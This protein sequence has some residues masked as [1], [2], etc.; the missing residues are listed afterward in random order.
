MK[1]P[2]P[3]MLLFIGLADAYAAATEYI[4]FPKDAE[5]LKEALE[6]KKFLAHP[7]LDHHAGFYTDDT[8][9]SAANAHVLIENSA[10]LTPLMFADAY[11]REFLRGGKRKGYSASFQALLESGLTSGQELLAKIEPSSKRNGA[12][13]RAV[14]LGVLKTVEEVLAVAEI[15]AK[16]THNTHEG[17]F[18]ARTVAL[19]S[20]FA[21]YEDKPLSGLA[22]Y[23]FERLPLPDLQRFRKVFLHP[24]PGGPV[25]SNER[26]TVAITTVHAVMSLL[27]QSSC[28]M[29]LLK[30]ALQLGGDTDSVAAIAWGIAS[31]RYQN[32][33]LPEFLALELEGGSPKTGAKYLCETSEALM[34]KYA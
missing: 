15:Q 11:V 21:L 7:S 24:W 25:Q 16:V 28:L 5:V 33:T 32:E 6:F 23:C 10:P 4:K 2:N 34:A 20:H 22:D 31:S 13:M 3:R 26:D 1:Y 29:D 12:A 19:M 18:S 9:M 27:T 30:K 17:I 14:P 8:E